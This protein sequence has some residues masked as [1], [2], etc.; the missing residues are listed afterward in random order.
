MADDEEAPPTPMWFT[1]LEDDAP[2]GPF[3]EEGLPHGEG[4]M[5]YPPP[6]AGEE[7]EEEK[8]G[9]TYVGSLDN[10]KR[11]G[12][13][14]Y[15]W[16]NGAIYEGDYVDNKKHGKGKFTFP[17]KGV[18]EGDFQEDKMH[19]SGQYT[20]SNGDIFRG[21]FADGKR[22]GKGMYHFKVAGCQMVGDWEEGGFVYG[23]WIYK[24][25][26]MFFGEFGKPIAPSSAAPALV[27]AQVAEASVD[28]VPVQGAYFY[29]GS[30]LIQKGTFKE[31]GV[32]KGD[33]P[34]VGKVDSLVGMVP[35]PVKV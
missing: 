11:L 23:R 22:H 17:D 14:K 4:A 35:P 19:G 10:G 24:D 20:Y 31:L 27:T 7:D 34:L 30:M 5:K 9:D 13:G 32:W 3:N 8:P 2:A 15:T 1:N 28:R 21:S 29:S 26:S 33:E 25:G 18:Y 6:P 16:S 12:K